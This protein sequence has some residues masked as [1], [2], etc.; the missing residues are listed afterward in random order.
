MLEKMIR[1]QTAQKEKQLDEWMQR[2]D[3][4]HPF[5]SET[6]E[7]T[8]DLAY[9]PEKYAKIDVFRPRADFPQPLPVIVDLHGGGFLLGFLVYCPEYPLAPEH[10]LFE[11][12]QALS[13]ALDAAAARIPGDGGDLNRVFLCGDSAGAWLCVYLAAMQRSAALSQAAGVAPSSLP[14]RALGLVSG[15]FYT[16]KLD[17]IG[18][19]L[20][21]MLYGKD[22]RRHPFRPYMNPEHPEIVSHLPPAMLLTA[23]GDFLRRYSQQYAKALQKSGADCC[24][25]DLDGERELPHAFAALLPEAPESRQVT[26]DMISFFMAQ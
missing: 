7:L 4:A 19:F 20:P 3:A 25:I 12:L 26:K 14:V 2:H 6:V 8:P 24:L 5:P 15:M 13:R 22:W 9:A 21:L 16:T 11:I 10:N 1:T 17:Q 23:R 18:L